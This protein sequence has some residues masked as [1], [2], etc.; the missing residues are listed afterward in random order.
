MTHAFPDSVL[1]IFCKA[2]VT[3]QVKTRLQPALTP[4]QATQA[5]ID[6]TRMTLDRAFEQPLC[7]V[8]LCCSPDDSHPFFQQCARHYPLTL[9]VQRGHDLGERMHL[10]LRDALSRYRYALL[11]GCDCPSLTHDNLRHA[12]LALDQGH[13]LVIAPAEDGGYVLIGLNNPQ[14]D[15]FTGIRWGSDQV[16]TSTRQQAA[17]LGL[18]WHELPVQWDVD[19]IE[20]W[21]R[22]V[23]ARSG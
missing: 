15:L 6:L 4:E 10:A 14:P 23:N 7:P 1:L 12:L 16:M 2:P 11:T 17:R 9:A 8:I 21:N 3:G 22:H 5:H 13:D 20:D 19:R 18:S